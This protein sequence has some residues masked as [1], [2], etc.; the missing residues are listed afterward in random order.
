[1]KRLLLTLL[2]ASQVFA[3][4]KTVIGEDDIERLHNIE[5][6]SEL[7]QQS[8]ATGRMQVPGKLSINDYCTVSLISENEVLTAAHCLNKKQKLHKLKV[9]FE[10]YDRAGKNKN[11]YF[12][13]KIVYQD[14]ES[15]LLIL[16]LTEPAGKKYGFYP[17]AKERPLEGDALLVI[18]HP[19][20]KP[21]SVS[22]KNCFYEAYV[23]ELIIHT[24]DTYNYSSGSPIFNLNYEIVGVHQGWVETSEGDYNYGKFVIDLL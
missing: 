21:K 11:P 5:I 10:Y 23:E 16:E 15:D 24:C 3:N 19:A 4:E 13:K 9:F 6:Q 2:L 22:R 14:K 20:L 1:M 17:I 12:V 18:Q 7:Y 8:K